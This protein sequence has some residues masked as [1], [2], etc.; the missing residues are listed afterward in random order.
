M[1]SP[2]PSSGRPAPAITG[3]SQDY[4]KAK[5]VAAQEDSWSATGLSCPEMAG[6]ERGPD[7]PGM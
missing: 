4:P 3:R 6:Q 7:R 2:H 5:A 1:H